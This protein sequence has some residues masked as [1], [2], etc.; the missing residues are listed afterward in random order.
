MTT[1]K[2]GVD[3]VTGFSC[4]DFKYRFLSGKKIQIHYSPESESGKKPPELTISIL[5]QTF[6]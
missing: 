6:I 4:I 5:L 3:G 2:K 1:K